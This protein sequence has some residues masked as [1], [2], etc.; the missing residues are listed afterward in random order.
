MWDFSVSAP[1]ADSFCLVQFSAQEAGEPASSAWQRQELP[2]T[3]LSPISET[4]EI[5]GCR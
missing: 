1:E 5:I 2:I 4:N 3:G